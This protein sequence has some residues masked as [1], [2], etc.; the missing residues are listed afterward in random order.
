[1]DWEFANV[2]VPSWACAG[3]ITVKMTIEV[4]AIEARNFGLTT[5]FMES[6][7]RMILR[8][9]CLTEYHP[10]LTPCPAIITHDKV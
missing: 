4:R 3:G 9:R 6:P 7:D 10:F 5:G 1:V 2:T 8:D